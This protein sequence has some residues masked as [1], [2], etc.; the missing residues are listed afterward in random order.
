MEYNLFKP[1]KLNEKYKNVK[2]ISVSEGRKSTR[3]NY[4]DKGNL[5]SIEKIN[6]ERKCLQNLRFIRMLNI[7]IKRKTQV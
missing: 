4:D 7:P 5:K 2:S 6:L 3:Y 1:I